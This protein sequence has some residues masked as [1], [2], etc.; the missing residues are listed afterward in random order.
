MAVARRVRPAGER[1]G[2]WWRLAWTLLYFPS[3]FTCRLRYGGAEHIP[4]SGGAI[5][6]A[7]HVS[8]VDPILVGRFLFDQHRLPRFLAKESLFH[9]FF[10]GRAMR[11]L[12]QIPVTRGT[13]YAGESLTAAVAALRAGAVILIYPEG[14][15]TRDPDGWPMAG[16]TGAARL[17]LLAPEIPLIPIAQW[18]VQEAYDFYKKRFRLFRRPVHRIVAG[19]PIDLPRD[20][21]DAQHT[22]DEMT[23]VIMKRL[24]DMVAD[25]RGIPA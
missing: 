15:V 25:L 17:A 19:P 22:I 8:H 11:G 18:G 4:S 12:G 2:F 7:N 10:V 23:D 1:L 14:T 13:A 24:R 16:K 5:L 6:V 9:V 3:L 20:V 21:Q